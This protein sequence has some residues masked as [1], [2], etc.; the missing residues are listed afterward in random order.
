[1]ARISSRVLSC[2][3]NPSE[4]KRAAKRAMRRMRTGSSLNAG[5]TWRSTRA[6][7]DPPARRRDRPA[8]H[9]AACAMALMVRSRRSRSSSSVMS[10]RELGDEAAIARPGLALAPGQRVLGIGLRMQ[11][12]REIPPHRLVARARE[13]LGAAADHHVVLLLHFAPQQRV[14]DRAA[15]QIHL[16]ASMVL[17]IRPLPV[18]RRHRSCSSPAATWR[19]PRAGSSA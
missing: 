7:D 1:M 6:C 13:F 14:P 4:A 12:H 5:D 2:T 16:H 10:G 15:D 17:K 3:V 19:R 8:S 11:E 9:P 18:A